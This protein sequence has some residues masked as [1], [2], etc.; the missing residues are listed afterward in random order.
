[1]SYQNTNN[2]TLSSY[3]QNPKH[4][5]ILGDIKH[6]SKAAFSL[7]FFTNGPRTHNESP[8]AEYHVRDT[9]NLYQRNPCSKAQRGI[10]EP[11]KK[12]LGATLS[13]LFCSD[14]QQPNPIYSSDKIHHSFT[15]LNKTHYTKNGTSTQTILE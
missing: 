14:N 1:M 5:K 2:Q 4:K 13:Y 8:L 7:G 3:Q 15:Q 10:S 9:R 11:K 12:N 6:T